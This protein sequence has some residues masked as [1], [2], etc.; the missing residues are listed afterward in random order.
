MD[1]ESWQQYLITAESKLDELTTDQIATCAKI[2]ALQLGK[3]RL[4]YGDFPEEV[5]LQFFELEK[6]TGETKKIFKMGMEAVLAVIVHVEIAE[7]DKE[8]K[9]H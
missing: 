1:T 2:L 4:E 9:K 5:N 6:M 3:Y 7:A 8:F